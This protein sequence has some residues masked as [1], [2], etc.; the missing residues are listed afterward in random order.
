MGWRSQAYRRKP[1]KCRLANSLNDVFKWEMVLGQTV[2]QAKQHG[3]VR[4]PKE[5]W[6]QLLNLPE[7]DFY[8]APMHGDMHA[9]NVRVRNND[10]IIIDLAN[11][12][13]GPLCADVASLEVWLAF[14]VPSTDKHIPNRA[15]WEMVVKD[16]FSP[17][18]VTRPPRLASADVGLDWLRGCIRQTRMIAGAICE[19]ETEY[20]TAIALHLLRRAQYLVESDEEDAYRR[21]Y[22]YFLGSQLVEWLTTKSLVSGSVTA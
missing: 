4:T 8:H 12:R 16:L 1:M 7:Q 11:A 3:S 14:Q 5:L 6:E 2:Q 19:C 15:V 13:D 17:V 9:E 18:E 21:G 10:A 22:A 20:P